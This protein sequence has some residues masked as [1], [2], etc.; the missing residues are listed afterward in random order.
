MI[1]D[2]LSKNPRPFWSYVKSLRQDFNTIP[3]LKTKS[4]IPAASD[5]A[6][7]NALV[8]QFSSVFTKENLD[9]LPTL[10][11]D[12]PDMPDISFGEE[13]VYKLFNNINPNKA[14]GPDAIPARFLKE[15]AKEVAPMFTH[16][17]QQSYNS[18]FL[19]AIW[20][21]ALVCPI[22]KKGQKSMPE[23][24]R[25]VS[26]TSIPCKIFEHIIVSQIWNHL[27]KYHII[28]SKQH[29]FRAGM[30]CETQLIEAIDEWAS[31]MNKGSSQIDVIVLDFSKA[32]DMVPH[33]RLLEKL[34][35]C[36][37]TGNTKRWVHSFLTSRTHEVVVNGT[38]SETQEVTSGVPQGTVLGPLLFL[39]YINDI[40][41][42]LDSTIR[43]FADDSALYREI[44]THHDTEIL[45]R[46]IFK[47]QNWADTWQ[48][49]F[50][51]KKC[52]TLRITRKTK[53]R[54][55]HT[56]LMSTPLS[57]SSGR[58]FSDNVFTVAKQILTVNP[59]NRNCSALDEITSDKYLG[60]ILD[61]KL[62][63]NEHVDA[64][65]SKAT[66][67]LNLCRRNL[68]MCSPEIKEAAYKS[69]IRPHLEYASPAWS[70]HTS[71]NINKIEAVQK[72]AARFVLGNYVYGPQ[73]KITE[74][75]QTELQWLP[76]R[77]RRS[78]Y[79]LVVFYKIRNSM[80]NV[81]FQLQSHCL[82]CMNTGTIE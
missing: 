68:Y 25:P 9:T 71:Q 64:I 45:Q 80:L 46:D 76:L 54:I 55:D 59:P 60:V 74:K 36:G 5:Q 48:M 65:C 41:K 50:N 40:E 58:E 26:L 30:S 24:Y 73:A 82:A 8:N 39:L 51:V 37:I 38:K 47:L 66:N 62:T 72:R 4:S 14:G 11:Q 33:M 21:H 29:G 16:L 3:T 42:N 52:K 1:G 27:N 18:G 75:I 6:K 79:D 19:P 44:K 2:S 32:F 69:L 28:T 67:L 81:S 23:N 43:L 56:Y 70:P 15:T 61:N 78:I 20:K 13:G 34:K 17:F 12:Y 57:E 35:S 31:I 49:S 63:F 10:P 53:H 77:Q 7:A 22:F